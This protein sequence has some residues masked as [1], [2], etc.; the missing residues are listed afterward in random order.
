[1]TLK[2][3]N[4]EG[5]ENFKTKFLT[6]KTNQKTHVIKINFISENHYFTIK[7]TAF[8]HCFTSFCNQFSRTI[9]DTPWKWDRGYVWP[10]KMVWFG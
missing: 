3:I 7:F 10:L 1:M 2:F 5:L 6:L 9:C 4:L 8:Y